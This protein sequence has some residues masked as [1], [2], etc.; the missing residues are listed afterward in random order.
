MRPP[1]TCLPPGLAHYK[2]TALFD[3]ASTPL[4]LRRE[5]CTKDGVWGRIVVA[6]GRLRYCVTD[7]RRSA[8][9]IELTAGGPIGIVEPTILHHVE[10]IGDVTFTVEFWRQA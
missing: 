8:E 6:S 7:P 9:D 4:A 1:A 3:A 10:P 2:S 5:H